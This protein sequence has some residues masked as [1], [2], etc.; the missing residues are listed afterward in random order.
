MEL[1]L[2]KSPVEVRY[3]G[4]LEALKGTDTG[5]KPKNW[6]MSPRAVRTFILGSPKAIVLR[7][8]ILPEWYS[9]GAEVDEYVAGIMKRNSEIKT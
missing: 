4:E 3:Q 8:E 2:I 9:Y 1:A 6:Q 5:R 7:K